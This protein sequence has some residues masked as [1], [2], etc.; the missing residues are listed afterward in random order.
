[1]QDLSLVKRKLIVISEN[2]L[3]LPDLLSETI[4]VIVPLKSAFWTT[5]L[6]YSV[7]F[8]FYDLYSKSNSKGH[9]IGKIENVIRI[10]SQLYHKKLTDII[11]PFFDA[12]N[13]RYKW[14]MDCQMGRM[15][16]FNYLMAYFFLSWLEFKSKNLHLNCPIQKLLPREIFT[17]HNLVYDF[18]ET[19]TG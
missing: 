12:E 1:M 14:I 8:L 5:I 3:I 19:L 2:Y 17:A 9:R 11:A 13:T 10:H 18:L 15:L 6:L 4:F 7:E 16:L